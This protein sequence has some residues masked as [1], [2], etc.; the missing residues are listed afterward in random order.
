MFAL[1]NIIQWILETNRQST[2]GKCLSLGAGW[3]EVYWEESW[4]EG[5]ETCLSFLVY[6]TDLLFDFGKITSYV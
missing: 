6:A 5:K 4:T 2:M 3:E 1:L